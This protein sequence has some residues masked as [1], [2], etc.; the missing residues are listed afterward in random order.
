MPRATLQLIGAELLILFISSV[1]LVIGVALWQ[2]GSY[3]LKN[4]KI[5][6]AIIFRN[7]YEYSK[8]GGGAYYPVV[9]FMTDKQEW[10]TQKLSIGYFP[11]KKE[12]TKLKVIYHPD[13]P[14][15]VEINSPLQLELLPR[16][17]VGLGVSGFVFGVLEYVNVIDL[18][19]T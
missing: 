3:L 13:D 5:A 14:T 16:L 2:K 12:G 4:G 9:R 8:S 17:F 19:P 1:F 15:N 6:D 18:I 10:I 11:A 7:E